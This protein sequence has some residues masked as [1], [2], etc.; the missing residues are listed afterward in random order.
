MMA[1]HCLLAFGAITVLFFRQAREDGL[2]QRLIEAGFDAERV[3]W[4]V[5]YGD[6]AGLASEAGIPLRTRGGI[7]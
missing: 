1:T 6:A 2:E 3:H 4:V 7:D 5:H